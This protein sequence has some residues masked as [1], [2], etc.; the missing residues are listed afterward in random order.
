[1]KKMTY[2]IIIVFILLFSQKTFASCVNPDQIN[3]WTWEIQ[4]ID[5]SPDEIKCTYYPLYW[6]MT[7]DTLNTILLYENCTMCIIYIFIFIIWLRK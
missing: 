5:N 4:F 2:K 1:M 7:L 6:I 3:F